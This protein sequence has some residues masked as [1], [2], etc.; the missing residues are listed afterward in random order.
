MRRG[1]NLRKEA[2]AEQDARLS[3]RAMS[4]ANL[5]TIAR[6]ALIAP[7]VWLLLSGQ[8]T[9]AAVLFAAVCAGDIL[10]G[11]VARARQEVTTL[12]KAL[13]PIVDKALYVSLLSSLLV[14]GEMPTWAYVA[15]LVPQVGLGV[16]A[17]VLQLRHRKIQAAR[18]IGKVASAL[19]FFGLFFLLVRWP[20]GLEIFCI[21][22]GLTYIAGIDYLL[23]ARSISESP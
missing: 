23:A 15:F 22:T 8:R 1:G 19:S 4:V 20:G 2:C 3:S 6:G 16:G 12:G 11:I 17:I 5:I 13:D 18:W 21:A 9:A 14:V 10:D 7:V